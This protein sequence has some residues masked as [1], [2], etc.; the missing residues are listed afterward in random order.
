[1]YIRGVV[2][3]AAI[4]VFSGQQQAESGFVSFGEGRAGQGRWRN[5]P[6]S[7]TQTSAHTA[8]PSPPL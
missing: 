5:W 8:R 6:G 3:K 2:F 1:M 4:T 7:G